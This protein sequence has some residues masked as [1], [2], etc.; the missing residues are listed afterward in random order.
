MTAKMRF[1]QTVVMLWVIS[2]S[3]MAENIM[4]FMDNSGS[5]KE[6][7]DFYYHYIEKVLDQK[8]PNDTFYFIPIGNS[9]RDYQE[10]T[11][12]DLIRETFRFDEQYTHI[13]ESL[14]RAEKSRHFK[15]V[16]TILIIS[17]MEPDYQVARAAWYFTQS[18]ISSIKN[19]HLLLQRWSKDKNIHIVL[20]GWEDRPTKE[21]YGIGEYETY[22]TLLQTQT[23]RIIF[24][25]NKKLAAFS[26][27]AL[28]EAKVVDLHARTKSKDE[29][30]A[31]LGHIFC[32]TLPIKDTKMCGGNAGDDDGDGDD[33]D[34][35]I[36]N[37]FTLTIDIAKPIPLSRYFPDLRKRIWDSQ[38]IGPSR[39]FEIASLKKGFSKNRPTTDF[40]FKVSPSKKGMSYS[41]PEIVVHAK[42]TKSA[43]YSSPKRLSSPEQATRWI[44]STINS[45][46]KRLVTQCYPP[47]APL[48]LIHVKDHKGQKF[49]GSYNFLAHYIYTGNQTSEKTPESNIDNGTIELRMPHDIDSASLYLIY[50]EEEEE[51]LIGTLPVNQMKSLEALTFHIPINKTL[52]VSVSSNQDTSANLEI[53]SEGDEST[54]TNDSI[55]QNAKTLY[56]LPGKYSWYAIPESTQ[57]LSAFSQFNLKP[58]VAQPTITVDLEDDPLAT[59]QTWDNLTARILDEYSRYITE[60]GRELVNRSAFFLKALLTYTSKN[61]NNKTVRFWKEIFQHINTL[62]STQQKKVLK[63]SLLQ[64]KLVDRYGN[65]KTGA[66]Q[67]MNIMFNIYIYG[68]SRSIE[69][70]GGNAQKTR[71]RYKGWIRHLLD[72]G[73]ISYELATQLTTIKRR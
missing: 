31:A 17:D 66:I 40:Y 45:E 3:V 52:E 33:D 59:R 7:S 55:S 5:V 44:A 68:R 1:S 61:N 35:K 9:N 46:L 24:E 29:N 73:Y 30:R 13:Y 57:I 15:N 22:A 43:A 21:R 51:Y 4:I 20:Q 34:N 8:D 18:E 71:K 6:Y 65:L 26:L 60:E 39:Q 69:G 11:S 48:K 27:I 36:S 53:I 14:E 12:K 2:C 41:H 47:P 16:D 49:P 72:Q 32:K 58:N 62:S 67:N 50:G 54:I 56:L 64:V 25:N 37:N 19:T 38:F 28:Y 10:V 70:N 63:R 23:R 42:C